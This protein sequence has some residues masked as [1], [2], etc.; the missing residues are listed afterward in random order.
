[1]ALVSASAQRV[2]AAIKQEPG[3]GLAAEAAPIVTMTTSA[4]R[5]KARAGEVDEEDMGARTRRTV[6]DKEQ[7]GKLG[8]LVL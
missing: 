3:R 8:V 7:G 6:K 5:H 1:M 4:N 2:E